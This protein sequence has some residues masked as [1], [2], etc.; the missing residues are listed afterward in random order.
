MTARSTT[1]ASIRPIAGDGLLH[2][3]VL[4][5]IAVLVVNDQVLKAAAPG[6]L[7]WKLSDVAGLVFF[8]LFIVAVWEVI[9]AATGRWRGPS[10]T[11]VTV[12]VAVT[13]LAFGAVKLLPA[14]ER[15]YETVLGIGQ[16]PF[17]A[18]AW[19]VGGSS[20]GLPPIV[21]VD[22]SRDPTDLVALAAL[23]LPMEIGVGTT[24]PD[25]VKL[26]IVEVAP[27]PPPTLNP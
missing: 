5:A 26:Q 3:L 18:V 23:W 27:T 22:L 12:A 24:D 10:A 8:P 4:A 13:G 21:P 20:V 17:A 25:G 6:P 7:T 19:V 16:W 9:A 15:L 11:S 1:L 14:A 2:P